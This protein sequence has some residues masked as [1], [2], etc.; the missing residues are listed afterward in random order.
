MAGLL[1][2]VP[3][4][5]AAELGATRAVVVNVLPMMP[6]WILRTA[7]RVFRAVMAPRPRFPALEVIE[8]APSQ[9]LGATRDAVRWKP[10]N[11][12]RW[13]DQGRQDAADAATHLWK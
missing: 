2:A 10:E 11:A 5:A 12:R 7:V 13:I 1:A 6:N 9:P 3:L 4:W 8:I